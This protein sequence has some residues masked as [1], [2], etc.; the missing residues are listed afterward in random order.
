MNCERIETQLIAYLDG[1]ATAGERRDVEA[2]LAE[3]AACRARAEEFRGVWTLLDEAPAMEPSL[4][5]DARVRRAVAAEP[6]PAPFAWLVPSL[7][8]ASAVAVLVALSVWISSMP[9]GMENAPVAQA[10]EE[11][12]MIR[13]LPVLEDYDVLA[14][15][16]VLSALPAPAAARRETRPQKQ[17]EM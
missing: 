15:F 16:E 7:R 13:D 9:P 3:C 11:F 2:H 1:K 12:R 4:G 6:S 17:Q 8:A 5:F 10:D 14:N